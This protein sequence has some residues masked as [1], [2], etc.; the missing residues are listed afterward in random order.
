M[1]RIPLWNG[2]FSFNAPDGWWVSLTDNLLSTHAAPDPGALSRI[3]FTTPNPFFEGDARDFLQTQLSLYAG[4]VGMDMERMDGHQAVIDGFDSYCSTF[5]MRTGGDNFL[6]AA[7]AFDFSG[8]KVFAMAV[9]PEDEFEQYEDVFTKMICSYETDDAKLS[10]YRENLIASTGT[11][12]PKMA[13]K[14]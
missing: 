8:C 4:N 7:F 1:V 14:G 10:E 6:G 11:L 13:M 9:A 3:I 12:W 5:A 2:M